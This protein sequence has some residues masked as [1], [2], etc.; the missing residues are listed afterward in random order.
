MN[1]NTGEIFIESVAFQTSIIIFE[2]YSSIEKA[3]MSISKRISLT[4]LLSVVMFVICISATSVKEQ[5]IYGSDKYGW[6]HVF[7]TINYDEGR[8]KT[9]DFNIQQFLYDFSIWF[10]LNAT[11]M[12]I[13]RL[14]KVKRP[15]D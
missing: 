8:I 2:K 7:Y 15:K 1:K 13:I 14:M 12:I 9:Q 10:G 6:P 4:F 11:V 5:H 3:D